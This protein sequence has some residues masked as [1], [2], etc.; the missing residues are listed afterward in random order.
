MIAKTQAA[1]AAIA[2]MTVSNADAAFLG[3]ADSTPTQE[4]EVICAKKARL[5]ESYLNS[6][7]AKKIDTQ[8]AQKARDMLAK[9]RADLDAFKTENTGA[10]DCAAIDEGLRQVG[11]A[12]AA[13]GLKA[14][15]AGKHKA[16]Y[17]LRAR[18][19]N[20]YIQALSVSS[21]DQWPGEIKQQFADT[22]IQISRAER[23]A[24]EGLFEDA[25]T[26]IEGAYAAMLAILRDLHDGKSVIHRL[27]FETPADEYRYEV[28]RNRSYEM[29]LTIAL[30]ES[31]ASEETTKHVADVFAKNDSMRATARGQ[32]ASG[33][34]P[35][36]IKTMEFASRELAKT[37][38]LL[39]VM[40]WD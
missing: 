17:E 25:H 32:A 7:S 2:A 29:L 30:D 34:Y 36:A 16:A 33:A 23:F 12:M 8:G 9:A 5:L 14:S 1:V 15:D 28:D 27:V 11:P 19:L 38:R 21:R 4:M 37:L 40:V 39:G 18:Q 20:A 31:P 24:N 35:D 10:G 22:E 13:S 26:M 6:P 3:N